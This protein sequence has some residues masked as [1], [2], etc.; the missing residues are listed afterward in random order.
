MAV[1]VLLMQRTVAGRVPMSVLVPVV[2]E[3]GARAAEIAAMA[4][5]VLHVLGV[6][7]RMVRVADLLD[8]RIEAVMLVGGVLDDARGAIGLVQRVSTCA[9]D[10]RALVCVHQLQ[11]RVP[12]DAAAIW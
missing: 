4:V 3:A 12:S 1:R 11:P 7:L 9:P 10:C 8:H 5:A 2:T 6:H